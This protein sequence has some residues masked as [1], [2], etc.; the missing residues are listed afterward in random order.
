MAEI[1]TTRRN[2]RCRTPSPERNYMVR[3]PGGRRMSLSIEFQHKG[4]KGKGKEK[5]DHAADWRLRD[6]GPDNDRGGGGG[7]PPPWRGGDAGGDG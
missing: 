5:T 1:D 2:M 3:T 4:E 7:D 6:R